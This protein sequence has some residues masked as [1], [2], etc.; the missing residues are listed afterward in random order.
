MRRGPEIVERVG[1][2]STDEQPPVLAEH[3]ARYRYAAGLAAHRTVL[4]VACG[5]GYGASILL[6]GGAPLVI[7]VDASPDAIRRA[8]LHASACFRPRLGSATALPV[9]SGTIDLI[10][11]FETIEH[12]AEDRTM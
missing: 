11:S 12:V 9:E 8:H 5:T 1:E 3:R 6:G 4:D 7:G 10:T 2:G